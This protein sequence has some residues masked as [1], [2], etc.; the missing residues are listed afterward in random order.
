M[1]VIADE[2]FSFLLALR[3]FQAAA[4]SCGPYSSV[5]QRVFDY[6]HP[7]SSSSSQ[8]KQNRLSLFAPVWIG[9]AWPFIDAPWICPGP[10]VLWWRMS[11]FS[12]EHVTSPPSQRCHRPYLFYLANVGHPCMAA[13]SEAQSN[14][15]V[16]SLPLAWFMGPCDARLSEGLPLSCYSSQLP[17][18][19]RFVCSEA[20]QTSVFKKNQIISSCW[21]WKGCNY[22]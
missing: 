14:S 19:G 16:W 9:T 3:R 7:C 22:S 5:H 10:G 11:P 17:T 20:N 18:Q 21:K 15:R 1:S 13:I 8:M 6:F 2:T 12:F 4:T